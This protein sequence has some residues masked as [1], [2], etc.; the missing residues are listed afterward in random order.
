MQTV[1]LK[2]QRGDSPIAARLNTHTQNNLL[3]APLLSTLVMEHME[4]IYHRIGFH[5]EII[6]HTIAY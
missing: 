1:C 6:Y 5:K 3:V 4:I 2:K